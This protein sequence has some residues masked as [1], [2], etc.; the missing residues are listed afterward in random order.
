MKNFKKLLFA[1]TFLA[2]FCAN[3]LGAMGNNNV[4]TTN[5][6][7]QINTN[8]NDSDSFSDDI[9]FNNDDITTNSQ[10]TD[11]EDDD[12]PNPPETLASLIAAMQSIQVTQNNQNQGPQ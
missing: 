5:Q 9:D 2:L 11:S 7:I 3:F 4:P 6:P 1:S 10:L 12:A 8:N